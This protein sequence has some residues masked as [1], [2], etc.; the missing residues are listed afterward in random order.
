[1][2]SLG[3]NT[4]QYNAMQYNTIQYTHTR[5][6]K[7]L[8]KGQE[9]VLTGRKKIYESSYCE[10]NKLHFILECH[11]GARTIK[12]KRLQQ[13]RT[14]GGRSVSEMQG[15]KYTSLAVCIWKKDGLPPPAFLLS[16]LWWCGGDGVIAD[17]IC[18]GSDITCTFRYSNK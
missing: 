12:K 14:V 15:E 6:R 13:M 17:D 3:L 16:Y 5:A 2:P 9:T 11:E 4:I 1:M 8:I 10:R 7:P 18:L